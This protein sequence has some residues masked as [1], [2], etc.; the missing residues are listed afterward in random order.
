VKLV[1]VLA[2]LALLLLAAAAFAGLTK[3]Y[4]DSAPP[5]SP[6]PGFQR[7]QNKH[8]HPPP[9]PNASE[10]TEFIR[11]GMAFAI[12]AVGGRLVFRL[13]LNP[14]SPSEEQPILLGLHRSR[15][16]FQSVSDTARF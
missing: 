9:A 8:R 1:R 16:E 4:G 14:A 7:F 5:P 6:Y 11:A 12:F 13:R 3:I 15:Q 2:R 10:F